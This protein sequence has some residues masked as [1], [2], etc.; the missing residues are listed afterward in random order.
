MTKVRQEAIVCPS[1]GCDRIDKAGIRY[2]ADDS[3]IQRFQ[4]HKCGY[5]FVPKANKDVM[6]IN[7]NSQLGAILQEAKKLD[8]ATESK[9]VAGDGKGQ[10]VEYAWRLKKRGLQD[11]TIKLRTY[12]LSQLIAKGANLLNPESV[13]TVLATENFTKC[14]KKTLVGVYHSFA[15]VFKIAWEPLKV[16]Y[17]SKQPFIPMHEEL[18]M[19]IGAAGKTLATFLQVALD[20]GA[21]CGEISKLKWTDINTVNQ[22][23]SINEPE[24][25]S[26]SRTLQVTEKTIAMLLAL[27]RKNEPYIFKP[28]SRSMKNSFMCLRNRLAI[29]HKEPRFKQIHL[30]TFRHYFACNLYRKTKILKTVQDALGHKS[31][32]NTEIYTRLVVFENEKYYST[33][34]K[35]V[36]ELMQLAEDGWSYFQEIDGIKVFRKPK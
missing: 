33:T 35:T 3:T 1:C 21:R 20:T 6:D 11:D 13:E 25:N 26:R 32:M 16:K 5:R 30:H 31:I 14:K 10:L 7:G 12:L 27:S 9:T 28:N 19:L 4:C 36:E 8:S 34:A 15:K 24:K 18:T 17:E 2:L 23:I 29:T 22:T